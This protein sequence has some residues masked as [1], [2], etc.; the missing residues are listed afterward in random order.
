[1]WSRQMPTVRMST[2]LAIS[3]WPVEIHVR[4]QQTGP[5]HAD[6]KAGVFEHFDRGAPDRRIKVVRER[7]GP[8]HH[9]AARA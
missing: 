6:A 7:V 5:R 9:V 4:P 3:S 8:Q 2:R 1:M